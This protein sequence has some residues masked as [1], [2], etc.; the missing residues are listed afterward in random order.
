MGDTTFSRRQFLS[1]RLGGLQVR[2]EPEPPQQADQTAADF[3]LS[4]FTLSG[5]LDPYAGPWNKEQAAHL[6][7]RATLGLKKAQLEQLL[8]LGNAAAAVDAVLDVPAAAPAPPV[9]DYNNPDYTDP[10]VPLGQTWVNAPFDLAAEGYRIE[11]WR[12]WWLDRMVNGEADIQEKMTLFWHNHFA[13]KTEALFWGRP[14]YVHNA[15]LRQYALGNFKAF[16]KAVTL[17]PLMLYFLNGNKNDVSAPDENYARELQ[18]LFTVGKDSVPTYSEDDVVAAARVLTGWRID[19][20]ADAY[21]APASHDTGFKVFSTFYNQT[22]IAGNANGEV[23]LDALLNM[24]FQKE[25]VSKFICRKIYRFFLYYKI[26]DT[27]EASIIEPMA[28]IFRDSNYE[29]KP[30]LRAFLLSEHFY[31]AVN[32]GCQIKSP[33][34]LVVGNL[35]NFNLTIPATTPLDGYILRVNLNYFASALQMRP[36]DPPNVA[37]WQAYYQTPSYYRVWISAD[38]IRNRNIF[39]DALSLWGASTENDTLIIDHVAFAAQFE[40][41]EDPNALVDDVLALL[42]SQP[43]SP[44]KKIFLKSILLSGQQSDYYWTDAWEAYLANPTDEMAYQT[45]WFRLASLHKYLMN[46]AEYQ[47]I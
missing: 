14:I 44:L 37:G 3:P 40:H 36:G 7:R 5:T 17:D 30:V 33:L 20:N 34:D 19:N 32:K 28:Q 16:V 2:I 43:I 18:E 31:E 41:P 26:D 21:F 42:F 45:V 22:I 12:G 9:N 13:T 29:I 24:I 8:A 27:I 4:D 35:R 39:T 10:V 25:E 6:L 11:S 1:K 38:T 15:L 23:E 46:L 47:L